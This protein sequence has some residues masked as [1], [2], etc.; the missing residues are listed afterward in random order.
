M[1]S[2][3][4]AAEEISFCNAGSLPLVVW[5]EPWA[6][7]FALP[8]RSIIV[9]RCFAD[10]GRNSMPDL[11][12]ANGIMTVWGQG[13]SRIAVFIDEVDQNSFSS[14]HAA[15][16]LDGL[17]TRGFVE[18]VF[19]GRPE[20]RPGGLPLALSPQR[21]TWWRRLFRNKPPLA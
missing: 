2:L 8:P 10:G 3:G 19:D 1:T 17:T 18:L 5:L 11:E 4:D 7:E 15:P 12:A 9:L 13:G 16:A 14:R 6:Q 20:T 21:D